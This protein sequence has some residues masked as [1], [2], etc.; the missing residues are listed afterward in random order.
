MTGYITTILLFGVLTITALNTTQIVYAAN[1]NLFVSSENSQFANYFTGAS[2]VEVVVVDPDISSTTQGRGE[3]SVT[4]NGNKLRMVQA[5]DGNWYG[6]FADR[7]MAQTADETVRSSGVAGYGLDFGVFCNSGGLSSTIF[8]VSFVESDAIALP[9]SNGLSSY[10]DGT[11]TIVDCSGSPTAGQKLNKVLREAPALNTNPGLPTG[12]IGI[13]IDAW[14]L[15]QLYNFNPTGNVI[16]QYQ[17]G[18]EEQKTELTFDT[19]GQ[20]A[21]LGLF[22]STYRP[23]HQVKFL[24]TDIQMNI[25]P[26]DEDSWTFATHASNI[27]TR[28]Q[29]F[30]ENGNPDAVC[31]LGNPACS[32]SSDFGS[33][34]SDIIPSL[35]NLMFEDNGV[36]KIVT[37]TQGPQVV[38]FRDNNDQNFD[39]LYGNLLQ[40]LT[41]VE[42]SKN[43]GLFVNYDDSD[44]ANLFVLSDAQFG[45]SA[46][47]G[48]NDVQNSILVS[49]IPPQNY[50]AIQNGAWSDPDTW[51]ANYAPNT[52]E[53]VDTVTIPVGITVTI[54]SGTTVSNLGVIKNH[55]VLINK[56]TINN[57]ELSHFDNFGVFNN[58]SILNNIS[59]F[60]NINLDSSI[61]YN[62]GT[63]T[64]SGSGNFGNG[65]NVVNYGIITNDATITN[66]GIIENFVSILN[67]PTGTITNNLQG[68]INNNCGGTITQNGVVN[69]DLTQHQ[70]VFSI[71]D[72]TL[73][74]GSGAEENYLPL[75]QFEIP[76][77]LTMISGQAPKIPISVDIDTL[78]NT[79]TID[80]NDY[81]GSGGTLVFMPG[82]FQKTLSVP[83]FGDNAVEDD[84]TFFVKLSNPIGAT[85]SDGDGIVTIQNDDLSAPTEVTIDANKDSFIRKGAKNTN[86]G[87]NTILMVQKAGNKRALISF[88][89][90]GQSGQVDSAILRLYVTYNGGNWGKNNDRMIEVHQLLSDWAEGNGANFVPKNLD[91]DDEPAKNRGTGYGVTWACN[92]D[93]NI[94]NKKSDCNTKWNGGNFNGGVV[95]DSKVISRT[96]FG[97]IEFDV[98]R[99]VNSILSGDSSNFGW[100]I[101]KSN[102]NNSGRIA[103]TSSENANVDQRPHLVLTFGGT[104]S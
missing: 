100:L 68:L 23:G 16:V 44:L 26:T 14:P 95:S 55:G 98:T 60:T 13:D 50:V 36:L 20:F 99:D 57:Q 7:T 53:L 4:V 33:G 49:K 5:T 73:P 52:L 30:D 1:P 77:T 11:N 27:Q 51:G 32:V 19:V 80:D 12:Q 94:S 104:P 89:L 88:D 59:R 6:Y 74:E 38:D 102:E 76:V 83:V 63:I 34:S 96:T 61:V 35:Q 43:S 58:T 3:P 10:V 71:T 66:I 9:R 56:G 17:K 18:G 93:S 75:T 79:A 24:L 28:Y 62:H 48:Y 22:Q 29:L 37:N 92:T 101:K 25:D 103:F 67:N 82:E 85:I 41:I 87:E 70:C 65:N 86:E 69:G 21:D 42:T 40:P 31:A 54:P 39:V 78:D 45:Y 81:A 46:T 64:N 90:S 97:W 47:I 2:I 84:E 15:I 8:G 91:E 72:V